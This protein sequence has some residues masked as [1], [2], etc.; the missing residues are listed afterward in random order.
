[1]KARTCAS[2]ATNGLIPAEVAAILLSFAFALSPQCLQDP[3]WEMDIAEVQVHNFVCARCAIC[4]Q[5]TGTIDWDR[6]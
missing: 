1:M 3:Y 2:K 4:G 6:I 5:L